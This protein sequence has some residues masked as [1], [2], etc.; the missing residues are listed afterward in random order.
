MKIQICFVMNTQLTDRKIFFVQV[1]GSFDLTK[2][3]GFSN[4]MSQIDEKAKNA[5]FSA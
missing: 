4:H 3:N 1:Q 2:K 5:K